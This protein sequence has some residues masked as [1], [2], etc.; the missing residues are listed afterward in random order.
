M[1]TK[2]KLL[3]MVVGATFGLQVSTAEGQVQPELYTIMCGPKGHLFGQLERNY[4][5]VEVWRGMVT[6]GVMLIYANRTSD[7]WSF[8]WLRPDGTACLL[9]HGREWEAISDISYG[10]RL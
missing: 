4:G 8:V 6:R 3:A 9:S 2:I 5:E 10:R 7:T 1:K